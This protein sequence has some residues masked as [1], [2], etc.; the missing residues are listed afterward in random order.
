M[1]LVKGIFI[2][3]FVC[4]LTSCSNAKAIDEEQMKELAWNHLSYSMQEQVIEKEEDITYVDKNNT[5]VSMVIN[6][7]AKDVWK[8]S[9]IKRLN[10]DE[11]EKIFSKSVKER[12]VYSVTFKTMFDNTETPL[13]VY[14]DA[15]EGEVIGQK[16]RRLKGDVQF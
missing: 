12:Y 15:E 7:A 1:K 3:S 13:V 11:V 6:H 16:E 8:K 10:E 9:I 5:G 2:F 14:V 4:I